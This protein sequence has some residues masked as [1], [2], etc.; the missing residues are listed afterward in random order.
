MKKFF[1]ILFIALFLFRYS[2]A[3]NIE[4]GFG[5]TKLNINGKVLLQQEDIFIKSKG[6]PSVKH[7]YINIEFPGTLIPSFKFEYISHNHT[8]TAGADVKFPVIIEENP[9]SD[10]YRPFYNIFED[11]TDFTD[12][13]F[14]KDITISAVDVKQ[15]TKAQEHDYIFYYKFYLSDYLVPKFGIAIKDLKVRTKYT[16]KIPLFFFKIS[17][18]V[19]FRKTIPMVYYGL[20]VYI[21]FIPDILIIEWNTEGK[22]IYAKRNFVLDLKSM[23]KFRVLSYSYLKNVY[24]AIGYRHWRLNARTVTKKTKQ[25]IRED[26]RWFGMFTE[27]GLMF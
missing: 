20:E 2:N 12:T 11:F 22:E 3:V 9:L 16:I 1:Y 5:Q 17:D 14:Y 4:A 6:N 25:E 7:F 10:F 27:I 13:D 23:I 24:F 19:E 21:P 15:Q 8:G 26:Y 18:E